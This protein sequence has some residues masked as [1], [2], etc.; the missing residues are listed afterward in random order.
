MAVPKR[1]P[2]T[3]EPVQTE[4]EATSE[5]ASLKSPFGTVTTVPAEL[6][7]ALLESGYTKTN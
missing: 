5:Y 3:P 2:P 6:V 7:P 4:P 1:K